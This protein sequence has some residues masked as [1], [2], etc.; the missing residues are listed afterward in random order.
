M[1]SVMMKVE[2]DEEDVGD[3]VSW[4]YRTKVADQEFP[5]SIK[6]M[7]NICVIRYITFN[8]LKNYSVDILKKCNTLILKYK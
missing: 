6:M 1:V 2:V 5:T 8:N 4:R 3:R 7:M